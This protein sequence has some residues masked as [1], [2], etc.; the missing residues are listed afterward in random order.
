[1][2]RGPCRKYS[3]SPQQAGIP[4]TDDAVSL[5][6][7]ERDE[8]DP[9]I[10]CGEL[11]NKYDCGHFQEREHMSTRFHPCNLNKE[12]VGCNRHDYS[13]YGKDKS[14]EYGMAI[15]KKYGAGAAVFLYSLSRQ[16]DSWTAN[17]L[18]QLRSAARIGIQG[19][20]TAL[21]RTPARTHIQSF[22]S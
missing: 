19:V 7:R 2:K 17:E 9:C 4:Q 21:L 15:D 12:C 1:M 3:K 10:V 5:M 13:G 8:K 11:K 22:T 6:I 14:F 16:H 18:S 20:R